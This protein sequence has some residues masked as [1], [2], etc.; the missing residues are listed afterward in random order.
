[1]SLDV[2]LD[3]Y[4]D[5][6][7]VEVFGANVTHNL[8]K[9]ASGAGIYQACWRPEEIGATKASDI[10]PILAKGLEKLK[11]DPGRFEA[12]NPANG[13]GSYEHFVLWVESYLAACQKF[14]NAKLRVSR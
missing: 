6:N 8:G 12:M 4:C 14:P 9:M 3:Y 7:D 13:W 1:M 2:Y 11:A 5:G 10:A